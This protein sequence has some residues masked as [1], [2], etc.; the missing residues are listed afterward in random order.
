MSAEGGFPNQTG[1]DG[2]NAVA[3]FQN[4]TLN[5]NSLG[6]T[7]GNVVVLPIPGLT[8]ASVSF[9][10]ATTAFPALITG[11]VLYQTTTFT[12]P[13][14]C[15]IIAF[16]IVEAICN[17]AGNHI[18]YTSFSSTNLTGVGA[19]ASAT[20]SGNNHILQITNIFTATGVNGASVTLNVNIA[21]DGSVDTNADAIAGQLAYIIIPT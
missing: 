10:N 14:N 4:L 6:I 19:V 20:T 7:N 9:A 18:L 13:Y 17:N 8:T 15:I 2:V 21:S 11:D 12:L 1:D 3:G 16:S 5:A